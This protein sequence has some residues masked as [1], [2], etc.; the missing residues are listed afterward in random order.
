ML[1]ILTPV[2][3]SRHLVAAAGKVESQASLSSC[4]TIKRVGAVSNTEGAHSR[5]Q[6]PELRR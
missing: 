2:S 4:Y 3:R 1:R 6:L 5:R